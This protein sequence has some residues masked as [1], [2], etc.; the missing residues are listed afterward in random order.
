MW[1]KEQ[2]DKIFFGGVSIFLFCYFMMLFDFPNKI[3]ILL[4][5]LICLILLLK[6]KK[7]RFGIGTC[8]LTLTIA[9]Y[10]IILYKGRAFTMSLPYVGILMYVLGDYL[11]CEVKEH[12]K[13][14]KLYITLLLILVFGHAVHGYLN[15]YMFLAGHIGE[16]VRHWQDIWLRVLIP[17]TQQ[18][19]YFLPVL[20]F[21]FPAIVYFKQRKCVN[22][23]IITSAIFFVYIS[24]ASQTRTSLLAFGLVFFAQMILYMFLEWKQMKKMILRKETGI[25]I[26][27][28]LIAAVGAYFLLKDTEIVQSFIGIMGRDGGILNNVR[29][30]MQRRALEQLFLYPMGGRHMELLGRNY[31]HNSWLDIANAAGLI[32][33]F[34]FTGYT[35]VI[36]YELIRWLFRKDV[37]M[38]RKLMVAG[39]FAIFFLYNTVERAF[40]GSMHFMTPWFFLNGMLHGELG[41]K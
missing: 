6:Q 3:T 11:S 27:I 41:E 16:T 15:S 22:I 34:A 4:G 40:E 8:L 20:A 19:V 25:V 17:G 28:M 24:M 38:E 37:S 26:L 39:L 7:F 36:I 33:F 30:Q 32:P 23:L 12:K 5:S 29:F 2:K 35:I 31:A 10:F 1:S 9:S 14:E 13:S 21:V 18:I